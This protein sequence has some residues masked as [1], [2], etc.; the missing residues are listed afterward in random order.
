MIYTERDIEK[1]YCGFLDECYGNVKIGP[2]E[3]ACSDALASVDP[4]AFRCGF[5]DWLDSRLGEDLWETKDG[6]YTDEE[7]TE[8]DDVICGN[9]GEHAVLKVST[10]TECCNAGSKF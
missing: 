4:T 10:G 3:Y 8:Q 2:L 7:P 9:C 5:A 6:D 1:Q